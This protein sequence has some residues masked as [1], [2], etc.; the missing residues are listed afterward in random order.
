MQKIPFPHFLHNP[1][2]AEDVRSPLD[3]TDKDHGPASASSGP[4]DAGVPGAVGSKHWVPESTNR[5]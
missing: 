1:Q 4:R 2:N 5:R 3:F